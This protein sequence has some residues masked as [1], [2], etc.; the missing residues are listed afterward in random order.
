MVG[1]LSEVAIIVVGLLSAV[2][3]VVGLLSE[4]AIIVVGPSVV[5]EMIII[6]IKSIYSAVTKNMQ[7]WAEKIIHV[8]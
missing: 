7:G 3:I 6:I 8:G 1:L 4:V 2:A 5:A